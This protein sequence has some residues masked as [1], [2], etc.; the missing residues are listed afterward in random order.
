MDRTAPRERAADQWSAG[1]PVAE[2]EPEA[3]LA[4]V[5]ERVLVDPRWVR[6]HLDDDGVRLVDVSSDRGVYAQGHLPGALYLH[7]RDDLAARH[8]PAGGQVLTREALSR[9][10]SAKGVREDDTL[11][12]YDDCLGVYAARAYW[13]LK[14]YGHEDVR[15]LDGGRGAWEQAGEPLTRDE[16]L[17]EPSGYVAQL[18][19]REVRVEWREVID[20]LQNPMTRY[21]DVR[22][23]MEYTGHQPPSSRGGHVPGA[24]NVNWAHAIDADGRLRPPEELERLYRRAGILPEHDVI[25][26]SQIGV[27]SS[28]TW[29]VLH[30]VLGYPSVRNYDGSWEEYSSFRASPFER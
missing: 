23:A 16:P 2:R 9:L 30:E 26:Y 19:K 14:Y 7:W 22:T 3:Q 18:P 6:E 20:R 12:L 5:R 29:F 15:L 27:R 13:V 8:S 25:V 4:A 11:V 21:L 17:R 10:F 28:H 1:A 24:V